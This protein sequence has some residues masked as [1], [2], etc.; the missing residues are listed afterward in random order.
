M[1]RYRCVRASR[2]TRSRAQLWGPALQTWYAGLM[3]SNAAAW[4]VHPYAADCS[5]VVLG[6]S[7]GFHVVP[8][9]GSLQRHSSAA[10]VAMA[11]KGGPGLPIQ[12]LL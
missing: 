7:A 5:L 6:H 12:D 1:T 3:L 11:H 4:R 9:A 10:F 8:A 2:A